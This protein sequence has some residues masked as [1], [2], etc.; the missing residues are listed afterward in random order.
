MLF[1]Q[2][3]WRWTV[4]LLKVGAVVCAVAAYPIMTVASNRIDDSS[5]EVAGQNWTLPEVGV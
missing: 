3:W 4:T 1:A 5:I 2:R